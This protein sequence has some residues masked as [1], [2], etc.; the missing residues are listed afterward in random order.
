MI[1]KAEGQG[2]EP[3]FPSSSLLLTVDQMYRADRAAAAAGVPGE[4]LMEA[5]GTAVVK[6]ILDRWTPREV[7]V[8]CG[9][10]NN[11]GDGFV[12]ARLL[13]DQGWPVRLALLGARDR[14]KGDARTNA[15]RWTGA[16]E[17]LDAGLLEGAGLVVDALFG[18]GLA[19]PLEGAVRDIAEAIG[20]Q[21]LPCVAVDIPSGVHGD[22]GA[23]LGAAPRASATVTFFRAKPGHYLFPGRERCGDLVVADIGIPES[24][25]TEI[26]AAQAVNSPALWLQGLPWPRWDQHKYWR[27]HALVAGGA[28]TTGAARLAARAA[29][30]A[31]AGVVTVLTPPEAA[32]IYRSALIGE[33]VAVVE[34]TAAFARR[35]EDPRAHAVLLGPGNGVGAET[36]ERVLAALATGKPVVLDADALSSFSDEPKALFDV[37]RGP[38][39]MTPHEG[40]FD[41][42]FAGFDASGGKLERARRA[43]ARSGAVV[44]LKGPDTVVAAPDGRAVVNANA[45]PYL[46]TAGTGDVLAGFAVALLAQGMTTFEAACAAA[47]M[48]GEAARE[49]GPGL[50]A[51]DIVACLP[52]VLRRLE[53]RRLQP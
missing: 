42:L 21:G 11:G 40:E 2:T 23:V 26:G 10:G 43:A 19:R 3:G 18:A 38:C 35:V 41:R 34:D 8:L 14:L 49:F 31:G 20:A 46:A 15:D 22:T 13:R 5:A 47:W 52:T 6:E 9:P 16:V 51:E 25:L 37:I 29:R 33:L 44:L 28:A 32:P 12:V 30:R 36:R 4:R 17:P 53:S 39:L 45:P 24:V 50:I 7:L 1:K 48:H 27:G